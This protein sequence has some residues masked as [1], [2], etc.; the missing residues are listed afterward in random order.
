MENNNNSNNN[1]NNKGKE[2]RGIKRE[3]E[4]GIKRNKGFQTYKEW[5]EKKQS[6]S[7]QKKK[8]CM[9]F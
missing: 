2:E 8:N 4:R 6:I 3:E 9:D 5:K 7:W 1:D